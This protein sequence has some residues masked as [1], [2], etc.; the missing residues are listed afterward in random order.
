MENYLI[1]CKKSRYAQQ[2]NQFFYYTE[3]GYYCTN[4]DGEG[5]F[6]ISYGERKQLIGNCDFFAKNL[7][8]F[9]YKLRKYL[10]RK[11]ECLGNI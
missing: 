7:N 4:A 11:K 10:K 6:Y 2:N 5:L 3:N 1:F 8:S 9:K